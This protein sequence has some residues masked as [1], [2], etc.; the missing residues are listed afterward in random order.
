M[1]CAAVLAGGQP[2][3]VAGPGLTLLLAAIWFWRASCQPQHSPLQ[4]CP[5]V[6]A[7]GGLLRGGS[8]PRAARRAGLQEA[9]LETRQPA[10]RRQAPPCAA[11]NQSHQGPCPCPCHCPPPLT[12]HPPRTRCKKAAKRCA[13][14]PPVRPSAVRTS[15]GSLPSCMARCGG[16]QGEGRA[17]Q[18]QCQSVGPQCMRPPR[19]STRLPWRASVRCSAFPAIPPSPPASA[20]PA[21]RA[22]AASP[23]A[24]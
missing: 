1:A 14:H 2:G 9:V 23:N 10:C 8:P 15:R 20:L 11:A 17:G 19:L 16:A 24:R 22:P 5:P 7:G 21:A 18:A 12:E 13:Q 4:P 3:G 6:H